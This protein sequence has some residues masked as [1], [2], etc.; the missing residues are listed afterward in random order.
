MGKVNQQVVV[1]VIHGH[2]SLEHD[3]ERLFKDIAWV[4]CNN[5]EGSERDYPRI[6]GIHHA[7]KNSHLVIKV[8]QW[9][10]KLVATLKWE[11]SP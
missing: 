11:E 2:T 3:Y 1:S 9:N 8:K 7:P 5:K 10:A 6:A 4:L